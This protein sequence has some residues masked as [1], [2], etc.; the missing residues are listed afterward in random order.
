M[1][2]AAFYEK[3]ITPPL[4]SFM[5]GNYQHLFATDVKDKLYAKALVVDNGMETVAMLVMDACDMPKDWY[6]DIN[7]RVYEYTCIKGDNLMFSV[8]HTHCGAPVTSNPEIGCYTDEDYVSVLKKQLAD[9][10]ILAYK[11]LENVTIKFAKG[12][13]S[14]FAFNRNFVMRNGVISCNSGRDNKGFLDELTEIDFQVVNFRETHP[15]IDRDIINPNCIGT[16]SGIDPELP[17][18]V[19]EDE[20]GVK[21]GA[22]INYTLHQAIC[23]GTELTGDYSSILSKELKKIYGEDFVS[24][25]IIGAA[26]DINHGD[27]TVPKNE[28][29]LYRKIGKILAQKTDALIKE[30]LPIEGTALKSIKTRMTFETRKADTDKIIEKAEQ[31]IRNPRWVNLMQLRNIIAYEGRMP[32]DTCDVFVQ[33]IRIGDVYIYVLPGEMYVDFGLYIKRNSPSE[34]NMISELSNGLYYGYILIREAFLPQSILYETALC[35]GSC[36]EEE[37][38]YA[39]SDRAIELARKLYEECAE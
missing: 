10:V 25:F 4:G 27:P 11:R 5:P 13:E 39:I 21:K 17:V 12:E 32:S 36:L 38:G 3:E 31:Y 37:A 23:G 14:N 20:N 7:R 19:F 28:P 18:L 1:F 35:E 6:V 8:N 26:G 2:K 22:V 30:A 29:E 34:K 24:L 33:V 9:C 15:E 16:L